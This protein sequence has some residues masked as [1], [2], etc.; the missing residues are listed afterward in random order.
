MCNQNASQNKSNEAGQKN[1]IIYCRVSSKRQEK[2]RFGLETQE[3]MCKEWCE[4]NDVDI[5]KIIKDWWI[6]GSTFERDGFY[7]VID[8]LDKQTRRFEKL[9]KKYKDRKVNLLE[10][11]V[12]PENGMPPITHFVCVDGSR[13]SRNEKLEETYY[14]TGK[15]RQSWAEI[16]YVLYPIDASS[17][18]WKLQENILYAFSAFERNNTRCKSVNGMR[19][20][21]TEWYRPFWTIPIGYVREKQWKNSMAVIDPIK[22]PIVKEALEMYA[23]WVL[24]TEASVYRYMKDK[25]MQT[26]SKLN[27]TGHIHKNIVELLFALNRLYFM[28]GFIYY[29]K[30]D[31]NELIPAKHQPLISM[32]TV[33]KILIKKKMS[34]QVGKVHLKTNPEFPLKDFIYCWHCWKKLVGYRATWRSA[35]YPYY[36]CANKEDKNRSQIRREVIHEEFD[37]LLSSVQLNENL[38]TLMDQTIRKLRDERQKYKDLL[39]GDTQKSLDEVTE[40]MK[41]VRM[42]MLATK[43]LELVQELESERELYRLDRDRLREEV[44]KKGMLSDNELNDCLVQAKKIYTWPRMVWD[45]SN[46]ELKRTLVNLL[47]GEKLMY[48]KEKWYRTAWNSLFHLVFS[49]IQRPDF[50]DQSKNKK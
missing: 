1:A 45:L 27:R 9:Q 7:E 24:E 34:S 42:T 37:K 17:S 6:S 36:G 49:L 13:I 48:T 47:F 43:N 38:R 3:S 18:A 10:I 23:N 50:L 39:A 40:K 20:R 29:P 33:E 21:L 28:A 46:S 22:W 11:W 30:R 41:R 14:M 32:E 25:W 15:I 5:V 31:I 35:K 19:A 12:N 44:E 4:R 2:E 8:I 16:I 26:N